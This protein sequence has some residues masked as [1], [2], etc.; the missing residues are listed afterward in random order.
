[1]AETKVTLPP[2]ESNDVVERAKGFWAKFSKPIIYVGSAVIILIGGWLAYVNFVKLP[3]EAKAD[4][5]IFP[6][7]KLFGKMAAAS[8]FP[9]DTVG[10]VLNGGVVDNIKVTGLLSVIK[11]YGGTP[12]GNRAQFIAGA[13]YLHLKEFDKAI[14]F[15]KDFDG[16][17]AGQIQS[18]AYRMLGDAY[19]EQK[20]NDDALSNYKKAI[21]A[22]DP[23]DES[24]KFL[25][26]S[27]AAMFCEAT[28][29]NKEAIEYYQQIKDDIS[30]EYF[31]NNR[32]EFDADKYLA[33]L[34]VL[35]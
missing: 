13:C 34:G 35:K 14:K 4:D 12:S 25:S 31:R 29:K 19:A 33:K 10:M 22:A 8:S 7:E 16:N 9:K 20:K 21:D 2:V 23:K 6:A 28:G 1:M 32:I 17:G 18:A 11:N 24:T 15:L 3:N 5:L 26:L 27:R 30:P